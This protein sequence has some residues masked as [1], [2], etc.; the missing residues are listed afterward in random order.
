MYDKAVPTDHLPMRGLIPGKLGEFC[1]RDLGRRNC[2][3]D[4]FFLD[5]KDFPALFPI[6][7]FTESLGN[8]FFLHFWTSLGV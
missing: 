6:R 5:F 2:T 1:N 3:S 7:A 4:L 8:V